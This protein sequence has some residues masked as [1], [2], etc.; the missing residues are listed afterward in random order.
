[1]ALA[2]ALQ[3]RPDLAIYVNALQRYA[4]SP[5]IVHVKR[6]NA[7]VRWAQKHPIKLT[8][9]RIK[10]QC[11][12]EMFSDAAFKREVDENDIASGRA[13][14]GAVYMRT[15]TSTNN[16]SDPKTIMVHLIDWHCGSIKQVTRSTFTSE[17]LACVAAVDQA[18]TLATTLH[19]I[20][21][22]PV[23]VTQTKQ[24]VEEAR[25]VFKIDGYVDAMSL[26]KA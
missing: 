16:R 20:E 2:Y 7:L 9:R 15:G 4:Q 22:G 18:I 6:L 21:L 12:L 5:R 8:Y 17:G 25:L 23:N 1:M 24:L 13:S 3:T 10:C 11:V 19:E 26:I 14:R